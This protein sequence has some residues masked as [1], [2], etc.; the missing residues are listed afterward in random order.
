[1]Y[2]STYCIVY[3]AL[4]ESSYVRASLKFIGYMMY[5]AEARRDEFNP[6]GYMRLLLMLF[7]EMLPTDEQ[8]DL[9]GVTV[10]SGTGV[11]SGRCGE[12]NVSGGMAEASLS[13]TMRPLELN[14]VVTLYNTMHIIRPSKLPAFTYCWL[15]LLTHRSIIPRFLRHG[16]ALAQ[17]S[18]HQSVANPKLVRLTCRPLLYIPNEH[19]SQLYS[20]C[21][22]TRYIHSNS[23]IRK[24]YFAVQY[25]YESFLMNVQIECKLTLDFKCSH[26]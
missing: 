5:E 2:K 21:T 12:P 16:A 25:L 3:T 24:Q 22:I 13:M 23:Y 9:T 17:N 14:L 10:L 1:M 26:R 20:H 19:T 6:I 15:E 18:P 7:N 4:F 11:H 8:L